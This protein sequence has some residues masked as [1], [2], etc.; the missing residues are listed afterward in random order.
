[1]SS[2]PDKGKFVLLEEGGVQRVGVIRGVSR[3]AL[4]ARQTYTIYLLE[5][6]T[7][8]RYMSGNRVPQPLYPTDEAARAA[9]ELQHAP[10]TAV[11]APP[12]A[13]IGADQLVAL[14]NRLDAFSN[15]LAA[16]DADLAAREADLAAQQAELTA[17]AAALA[18]WGRRTC[19]RAAARRSR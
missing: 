8:L 11:A 18:P 5:G 16:V 9:R 2:H 19:S 6:R 10:A 7:G 15:T 12:P 17:M 13:A 4:P 3:G 1:M 14:V